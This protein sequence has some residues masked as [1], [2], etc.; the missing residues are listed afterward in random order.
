MTWLS[1][2]TRRKIKIVENL[3]I[4]DYQMKLIIHK[5]ESGPDTST[6]IYLGGHCRD[7]FADLRFTDPDQTTLLSYWIESITGTTPNL[8]A[9]VWIKIPTLIPTNNIYI[10]YDNPSAISVSD[11]TNTFVFFD[12]FGGASIDPAKWGGVVVLD[13]GTG[14][15]GGS[16]DGRGYSQVEFTVPFVTE[17]DVKTTATGTSAGS[18]G[19]GTQNAETGQADFY[20]HGDG[21]FIEYW[22]GSTVYTGVTNTWYKIKTTTTGLSNFQFVVMDMSR[23]VLG[24]S[25]VSTNTRIYNYWK[26]RDGWINVD[27]AIVWVDKFRIRKYASPEPTFG[28]SGTEELNITATDMILNTNTCAG[29]CQIIAGVTWQNMGS[30]N[31][32]FTPAILIDGTTIAYATSNITIG[33]YPLT[34]SSTITTPILSIGTHQICPYPN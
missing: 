31:V 13:A 18:M 12:D 27:A 16:T 15:F 7:D 3:T 30:S 32:T 2:W 34:G 4:S 17:F 33:P 24:T 19:I 22:S 14:K 9:I 10:Y 8:V 20:Q 23:N 25:A 29:S 5:S 1:G 26:F 6:D 21:R 11:G 28:V